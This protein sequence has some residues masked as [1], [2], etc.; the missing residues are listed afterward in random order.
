MRLRHK[1]LIGAVMLGTGWL[2]LP[3]LPDGADTVSAVMQDRHGE[4][5]HISTVEDGRVRL[6]IKL[7]VVDPAFVEALVAMEDGRF[8]QHV[9]VDPL[10]IGRA[11]RSNANAGRIVSGAS[12][13]TQQLGR[14]YMPRPRTLPT[15]IVEAFEAVRLD[16]RMSKDEQLERYLTRV[17]YGSNI[18]GV[19]AA[20]HLWLGKSPRYLTTDEI[21]LLL[22]LPQS[23][24]AR[25][26]DRNPVAAKAGRDRIL[27]R[28]AEESLITEAE[29]AQARRQPV[30]TLKRRLPDRDLLAFETFGGGSTTL[31]AREQTRVARLLSDWTADQPVPV[32]AAAMVVHVPTREVRALVGTGARDHAGGWIDMTDRVRSPGSTLKPFIYALAQDDG[33][34][35]L[36]SE[37]RDAPTRFGS[38]RPENFTRRYHGRVTVREALQHSLNVPA[39]AALHQVGADRFRA[40]L[41]AAGP[42][43]RGRVGDR[44]GEGLAL[45]LGGTGLSARDLAVLYTALG[46]GG[47]AAPLKFRPG[48]PDGEDYRLMSEDTAQAIKAALSGAPVPKGF[49]NMPG[50]GRVAYKTGTSYG[51]RDS[52]AAGLAG[53]HAVIVWTGRPD[54]APRPGRTGRASAAPI[55]F[56]IAMPFVAPDRTGHTA[57]APDALRRVA[58][59]TDA[60]PVILFPSHGTELLHDD[61]GVS[62]SVDSDDPVAL[63]VSGEPVRREAGLAVW[64]PSS[65]GFYRV[66]AVDARGRSTNADIR[67][68]A[69]DQ[70]VDAPPQFR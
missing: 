8:R 51:F 13:L 65:P 48:A 47:E 56:D 17:S 41:A 38:Y 24:E 57:K 14:Q 36:E 52:W 69:R 64:M 4:V 45:A 42:Q 53:D 58:D 40:A 23:P 49:A 20:S 50:V 55:L 34:L 6:P 63:F 12:T 28:M 66:S 11:V 21:A 26:P 16:L 27:D 35:D 9:G 30:P 31:D 44:E 3:V 54:G 5:L 10:A 7:D 61:R 70:L 59:Q 1:F 43:A 60:G 33:T 46:H 2:C 68:V 18:E 39:V 37:V 62:I 25:R 67:V 29:A 32:N 19:A 15:K 22:A